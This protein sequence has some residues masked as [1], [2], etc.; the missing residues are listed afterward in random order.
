M[1][2]LKNTKANIHNV[3]IMTSNF[4]IR[5]RDWDLDYSFHSVH[6]D[7][8]LNIVD[9]FDLLFHILLIMSPPDTQT[10]AKIQI[11]SLT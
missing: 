3:L 5:D 9:T 4:N 2:Y 1:K 10:I 7:L 6:S 11:W 8:L